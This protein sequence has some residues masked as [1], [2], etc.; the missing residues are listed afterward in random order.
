[1]VTDQ[2]VALDAR[3]RG[4][5]TPTVPD[6]PP[7]VPTMVRAWAVWGR[8][9]TVAGL[10]PHPPNVPP[11]PGKS[12]GGRRLRRRGTVGTLGTVDCATT[13]D[14]HRLGEQK[15]RPLSAPKRE[16]LADAVEASD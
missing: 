10:L 7:T 16:S 1:M 9:G 6:R 8:S 3:H 14:A 12:F 5:K 2:S 15:D 13:S 11:S 4:R